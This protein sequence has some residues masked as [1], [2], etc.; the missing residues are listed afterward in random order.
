MQR[1]EEPAGPRVDGRE[2]GGRKNADR[3][4][5][6][7]KSASH[8]ELAARCVA[9]NSAGLKAGLYKGVSNSECPTR[10]VARVLLVAAGG[11][12]LPFAV[13]CQENGA[14]NGSREKE[15]FGN[16]TEISVT[17]HDDSGAPIPSP[18][19]VTVLRG[20]T[21]SARAQTSRGTA[22]L[23]VNGSGGEL[24]VIVQAPGF[25]EA[26]E[27]LSVRTEGKEQVDIYLKRLAK[28]EAAT[29]VP[30]RPLLAPKAKEALD[31]GLAALSA[32]KMDEAEKQ[33]RRAMKLAPGNPDVLYAEGVL[34]LKQENF[35]GAESALEKATQVDPSHARAFAAL[36]MALCNEEKYAGA[37]A[38][39][40]KS[41]QLDTAGTWEARWAL[42]K[43][44]YRSG[45]YEDAAKMS[46]S[47]LAGANGREPKIMLLVAQSETAVGEYEEAARTLREF[48]REH[49]ER[50]EAE[51]ARRWLE[52]LTRDGKIAVETAKN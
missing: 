32:G 49:A 10:F 20:A 37:I 35:A 11:L 44:Y 40:E 12:F 17:V 25:R 34:R 21:P 36:G 38:A 16:G 1:V 6:R 48:L 30:G 51:T 8:S 3:K 14:D 4:A 7:Y 13:F 22:L 31:E 45:R 18:A 5:G 26:R 9:G 50:K 28:E 15:F 2:A 23:V 19:S 33:I 27:E 29:G 52:S 46:K 42:A 47:A 43:A 39:L 41:L 24:T